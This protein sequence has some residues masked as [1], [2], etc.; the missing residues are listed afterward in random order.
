MFLQ[1]KNFKF[2][3]IRKGKLKK[4]NYKSNELKFGNYGLKL[5]KSCFVTARQ[6]EAARKIISRKIKRKGKIWICIF[7]AYPVTS[8]G[9]EARMGK[10]KGNVTHWA[11]KVEAGTI[12]FEICGVSAST[13]ISALKAGGQKFSTTTQICR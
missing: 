5:N 7:P 10:G 4:F 9:S 8:K 1:P 6:L 3:K 2:K 13:A 12:I 11:A